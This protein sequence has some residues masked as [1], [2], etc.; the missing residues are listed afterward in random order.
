MKRRMPTIEKQ[1]SWSRFNGMLIDKRVGQENYL[2]I[3]FEV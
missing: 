2:N 1:M 3:S